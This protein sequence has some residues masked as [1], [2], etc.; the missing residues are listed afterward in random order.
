M[1]GA[2]GTVMVARGETAIVTVEFAKGSNGA[3]YE[4]S[5]APGGSTRYV[6]GAKA[7][8]FLDVRIGDE[9][10]PLDYSIWNPD[11]TALLDMIPSATPYRGQ[12]WQSGDHVVE[13]VNRTDRE[14]GYRVEFQI[15]N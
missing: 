9:T 11:G 14:T 12:L 13:I 4:G 3:A 7:N 5:L 2:A 15:N 6:L 10:G 1:A 8:Q